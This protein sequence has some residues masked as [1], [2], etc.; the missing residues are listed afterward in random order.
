M[1]QWTKEVVDLSVAGDALAIDNIKIDGSNIGHSDDTDLLALASGALTLNGSISIDGT[2]S[3]SNSAITLASSGDTTIDCG[4]DIILDASGEQIAFKKDGTSRFVFNLDS[5]PELDVTGG[6]ILDCSSTITLEG[7]QITL[8]AMADIIIDADGDNIKFRAGGTEV[9]EFLAV[10]GGRFRL[11]DDA[12]ANDY[13]NFNVIANGV[14]YISTVDND[15]EAGHLHITADGN[16]FYDVAN[17]GSHTWEVNDTTVATLTAATFACPAISATGAIST[18]AGIQLSSTKTIGD[19]ATTSITLAGANVTIAGDL[20]VA[21]TNKIYLD[22]GGDTY[23]TE[24]SANVV[25]LY[26]G[27][28]G[29]YVTMTTNIAENSNTVYGKDA[30]EGM[31]ASNVNN[32]FIGDTVAADG[33]MTDVATNNTGIGKNALQIITSGNKNT[34]I[35]ASTLTALTEGIKNTAVGRQA[36]A[37]VIGGDSN[38]GIGQEAGSAITTGSKNIC[39]GNNSETSAVGTDNE[40][41][42]GADATGLGANKTVIGNSD[43]TDIYMASDSG[44]TV[45]CTS[46]TLKETTTP[47]A[48][49]DHG[50]VY[51]KNDNKLYFQDGAGTE[52]YVD[53]TAV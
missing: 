18:T 25:R 13:L 42:I 28:S 23:F 46:V 36:L 9:A 32:T 7:S 41:V 52:Y 47:T 30:G 24:S 4:A 31:H 39:I 48:L 43:C 53:I 22:G 51:T 1:P 15:G 45:H 20:K 38:V 34:A 27:S 29:H 3:I 40:I 17:G 11:Y 2:S 35:G 10:G 37:A 26:T 19:G 21:A 14:S 49:A 5:S 6:F 8:D 12:T 50:K 44:A 33:T 16:M